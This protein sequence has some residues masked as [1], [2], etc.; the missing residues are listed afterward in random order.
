MT[1]TREEIRNLGVR[2][3]RMRIKVSGLVDFM[4]Q[5]LKV[6]KMKG[7]KNYSLYLIIRKS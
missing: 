1:A 2:D 7:E 5:S 3:C 4:L 6:E